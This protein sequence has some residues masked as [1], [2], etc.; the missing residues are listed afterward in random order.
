MKRSVWFTIILISILLTQCRD[1]FVMDI[2]GE[3]VVLLS[4]HDNL[5]TYISTQTFWWDYVQDAENY[6]L[7]VVTPEFI[8]P[9]RLILDTLLTQ[10]KFLVNLNPGI[11][12]WRVRALNSAYSTDYS[13]YSFQIDSTQDL[14]N[15]LVILRT[16]GQNDTTN[17]TYLNFFWDDLYN[18]DSFNLQLLFE[19][20]PQLDT[21]LVANTLDIEILQGQG[22]YLWRV[23]AL[24]AIS[25]TV[26]SE[27]LLYLDTTN[28]SQRTLITP[29]D[30]AIIQ[31]SIV[32]CTWNS[33]AISGSSEYDSIYIY[34]D[35][36]LEHI[37]LSSKVVN[38]QFE[39]NLQ[40]GQYYWRVRGFDK[41]GNIGLYTDTWT[42]E[43]TGK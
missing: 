33:P 3:K 9:A 39:A 41:A 6:Q 7:Q 28:P 10:N 13:M 22:A 34:N 23:L 17:K 40:A 14:S 37:V 26:F 4:P 36:T 35:A 38:H 5:E 32:L 16:P 8:Q 27:R 11:Y 42:F 15:E 1:V 18:A 31:D 19:D 30:N 43:L 29:A 21:I 24:N 20:S 2:S 25:R 12:Q